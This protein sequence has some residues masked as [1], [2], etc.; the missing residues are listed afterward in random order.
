MLVSNI[1]QREPDLNLGFKIFVL[2]LFFPR[3]S[4]IAIAKKPTQ[5]NIEPAHQIVKK[6]KHGKHI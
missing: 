1:K 2:N 5:I 4:F 6:F 3:T